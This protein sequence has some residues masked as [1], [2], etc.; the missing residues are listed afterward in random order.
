MFSFCDEKSFSQD[1]QKMVNFRSYSKFGN[2]K[3][4]TQL[5]TEME[6]IFMFKIHYDIFEN[7]FISTLNKYAPIKRKYV[8]ANNTPYTTKWLIQ[9][10]SHRIKLRNIFLKIPSNDNKL[11]A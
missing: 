6:K 2:A 8:R 9:N 1:D 4:K 7:I 11:A 5:A 3:F 10:I